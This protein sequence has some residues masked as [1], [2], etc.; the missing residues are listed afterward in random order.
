MT[1][2]QYHDAIDE[3]DEELR[4]WAMSISEEFRPGRPFHPRWLSGSCSMTV[5][6]YTHFLYYVLVIAVSRLSL[7]IEADKPSKRHA[8][9]KKNLMNAARTIVEVTRY[10]DAEAHVPVW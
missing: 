4:C 9:S 8:E 10:I 6:I 3:V 2:A 7:H 1:A 5:A